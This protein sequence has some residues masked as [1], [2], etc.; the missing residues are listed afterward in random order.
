MLAR[1]STF[2][3]WTVALA[4]AVPA[5]SSSPAP[6]QVTFEQYEVV[7]GTA[8]RQTVLTGSLL[9]G[10]IAEI[11]VVNVD[12]ND[13]RR[14]RIYAFD[15][16][17]WVP[18]LDGT[19]GPEVLFMDVANIG[20]RDRLVT[21]EPGR[22]NWFDPE[23]ASEHEL[24]TVTSNFDRPRRDEIP[25]VDITRD[26]NDDDRDDL[27]VPDVDGFW[28][29]VQ[30]EGG[31]FADAVKIGPYTD[32]RRDLGS[33]R[34]SIRPLGSEPHPWDGLQPRW[35]RRPRVLERGPLRGSHTGRAWAVCPGE[36]DLRDR[37]GLRLRRSL[38]ACHRRHDREGVAVVRR[39]ERRRRRRSRS[40]LA[41]R[42]AHLQQAIHL[43]SAFRR[44]STRW[45][46]RIR[47]GCRGYVPVEGQNPARDGAARLR[48]RTATW[49]WC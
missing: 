3:I 32:M 47:L 24:V 22:L 37:C 4:R 43:R 30:M 1:T 8:K 29:F 14:L 11:G 19:L 20:G 28:V 16:D 6:G 40:S 42:Q 23:S 15:D 49:A 10:A 17:T 31:T 7:T 9:G 39:P 21:Y 35:S 26:V 44:A 18:S 34:I 12:D 46:H 13:D 27:V 41:R 2:I 45:R 38:L 5:I 36:R 33:R 25:H 48:S